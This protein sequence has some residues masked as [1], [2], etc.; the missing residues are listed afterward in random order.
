MTPVKSKKAEK[1]PATRDPVA[2]VCVNVDTRRV[3]L[4]AFVTCLAAE[5]VFV[6]LDATVNYSQWTNLG[7]IRRMFN[8]TREDGMASWFGTTQTFMVA[9]TVW[10]VGC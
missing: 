2:D 9:L 7:M 1:S 10:C 6:L 4:V 3:I 5:L 8:I